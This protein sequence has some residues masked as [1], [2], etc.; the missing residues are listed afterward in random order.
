M[1]EAAG[2]RSRHLHARRR[3]PALRA[4]H[5]PR[6]P[7]PRLH[8]PR[9][10][11]RRGRR[12]H[13]RARGH[14]G[15]RHHHAHDAGAGRPA[16]AAR[17]GAGA[18]HGRA[19]EGTLVGPLRGRQGR[20][21]PRRPAGPRR[22]D[23]HGLAAVR[24]R[25]ADR[26]GAHRVDCQARTRHRRDAR[27]GVLG[28]GPGR[29]RLRRARTRTG[30]LGERR[31]PRRPCRSTAAPSASKKSPRATRSTSKNWACRPATPWPTTR[32]RTTTTPSGGKQA[33]SD[34]YFLRVRPFGKDFKPAT[35]QAGGGGG[36]GGGG[37]RSGR[38][39]R[40]AA[41]DH[42]RHVQRAA[43]E[44]DAHAPRSCA[45]APWCWRCRRAGCASR[46]KAS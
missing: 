38:A 26:H 6:V 18:A 32:A 16:H 25:R 4:A 22:H 35:S 37:A 2:V 12:R 43:R 5:R 13:R 14:R 29:R 19:A 8:R 9:A 36:G 42:R 3:G 39:L 44:E 46:S 34:M 7:L 45:R 28:R 41:P 11:R 40:T 33:T 20:L 27:R 30:L 24:H 10:A 21:L 23:G 15:D 31:R 1:A 17:V